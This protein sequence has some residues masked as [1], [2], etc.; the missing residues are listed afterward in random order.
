MTTTTTLT[1]PSTAITSSDVRL[2]TL[3]D[4][5]SLLLLEERSFSGERL[6]R[7]SFRRA[8]TGVGSALLVA[9]SDQTLLGYALLH[10]R[11]GTNL[12]RL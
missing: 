10:L 3:D 2:A 12:A 9:V 7:R 4:L 5:K 1:H 8:I 6:S 11:Q